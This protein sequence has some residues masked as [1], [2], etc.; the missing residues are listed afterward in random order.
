MLELLKVV[1][2]GAPKPVRQRVD[3]LALELYEAI[4]LEEAEAA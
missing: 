3:E 1:K 2:E 4:E